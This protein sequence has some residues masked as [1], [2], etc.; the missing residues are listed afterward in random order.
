MSARIVLVGCGNMG[1]AML[2]GWLAA[3][4][5]GPEEVLVVEPSHDNAHR[6]RQLGVETVGEPPAMDEGLAPELVIF[7]VKPQ[8]IAEV[9]PAWRPLAD[10]GT[11][12]LSVL[13]GTPISAFQA[14]LGQDAAI[15]RCMP[16]TPASI[17]KGMMV[18][19][20]NERVGEETGA[21]VRALLSANGEVAEIADEALM[22]AVTAVSGSGPAYLFHF[23]ECLAAAG[24]AAGLPEETAALL[25]RQTAFGAASLVVETMEDPAELRRQVTSPNGTT[26]AA[27]QVLMGDGRLE[28]LLT[29]AVEAARARSVELGR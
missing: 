22:D 5:V 21:L 29:D 25:A 20:K 27:L 18:V 17:G 28:R 2:A 12:F 26:H 13:A 3:G 16:N 8:G 23:V 19:V 9:A 4:R 7:A 24:R 1:R 15:I 11:T 6:A 10:R 14:M